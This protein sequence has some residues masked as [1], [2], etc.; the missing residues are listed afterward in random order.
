MEFFWLCVLRV[1]PCLINLLIFVYQFQI[2]WTPESINCIEIHWIFIDQERLINACLWHFKT[3]ISINLTIILT[4]IKDALINIYFTIST[5]ESMKTTADVVIDAVFTNSIV[6]AGL[7][8]TIIDINIAVKTRISRGTGTWIVVITVLGK[9]ILYSRCTMYYKIVQSNK[10]ESYDI[11]RFTTLQY[12]VLHVKT[13]Q[14]RSSIS[15]V[16]RNTIINV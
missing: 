6:W 11:V 5:F 15:A 7:V 14:T 10:K 12:I 16:I 1:L 4:R 13:H 2:L 3:A 9:F 8:C